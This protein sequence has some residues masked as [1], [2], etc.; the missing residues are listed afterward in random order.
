VT[1]KESAKIGD[2]SYRLLFENSFDAVMMTRPDGSV[3][4]ANPAACRMFGMSE[5]EIVD[6][7]REG[8]VVKDERLELAL[9]DRETTGKVDAELMFRRKDGSTFVGQAISVL[10]KEPDGSI[11]A[12]LI[13]RDITERKRFEIE[14]QKTNEKLY[15]ILSN[16]PY[17]ILLV[18]DEDK[19]EFANQ[20]FC[21]IFD[22]KDP[23]D[24]LT[25]LSAKEMIER[26]RKSYKDPDAAVARISE[27]VMGE[28]PV[29]DED[30]GMISER[31]YLRDFIPIKLMEKRYGRLWI[32]KD[33]T[34][35]M[36][37]EEALKQSE[38]RFRLALRNA[39]VSVA[40]QDRDLRFIWAYNQ[41]SA[42]HDQIIGKLDSDI[43]T[44]EEAVHLTTLKRRVID[45]NIEISEKMW[46]DRPTGKMFLDVF[47]EPW[48]DKEGRVIGVG[49]ATV[50][51]TRMK[52]VE[53]ALKENEE[54]LAE[55]QRI[56][57]LGSWEWNLQTGELR[58]SRQLYSIYGVDPSTFVPTME[59]FADYIHPDDRDLVNRTIQQALSDG[60]PV[61]FD[62]RIISADGSVHTLN[63]V[64]EITEFD[65]NGRP[66]IM[67]GSN[68]DITE[69]KK[70]EAALLETKDF[71]EKL[72][73][74]ANAPIIVWGPDFTIIRF[75][76][77]FE[78][79]TG[80]GS[81][82]VVGRHLE[83][84][85]PQSSRRDS[86]A[87][88]AR[89]SSGEHWDSVEI[90]IKRKDGTT[91]TVLWNS[92]TL[93]QPGTSNISATIAQGQ[94]ITE[95]VMAEEALRASEEKANE[96]IR[97]SPA[98]I[99]ELDYRV[100][101]FTKV[102]DAMCHILGYS[103]EELLSMSPEQIMDEES[104]RRFRERLRALLSGEKVD[105]T[106]EFGVRTKD[107][108]T[109]FA[110]LNVRIIYHAGR[111]EGAFVV[112]H[113]VTE[114][115]LREEELRRSNAELQ[116]FA[117]VASHDLQEPL[118]MVVSHLSL[119]E[120]RYKDKLDP[121]AEEHIRH[122]VEGGERMRQLIDDLLEYSRVET[123][124]EPFALVD[125]NLVVATTL[126]NLNVPIEENQAEI[127]V[128]SLPTIMAD[129]S[130]M[131][132]VIQNLV[133][134]ALKFHSRK[135][136][137]VHISGVEGERE[138]TF[139]VEDNGIGLNM[140]YADKIF[141]MFQRLHTRDS[142][143]GTGVGLAIA[144]K[145]VERHGGRIWVES[146]EGKGATFLF[147]IPKV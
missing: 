5:D 121:K 105:D 88:I 108:R 141:Q 47:Y 93:F 79:L 104:K 102:N 29:K 55:A 129:E 26:I 6:A 131:A 69:R 61:N 145:I 21:D 103:R 12:S 64:G 32:H 139:A 45:E 66:R 146:E 17:G 34:D 98:G 68:L 62:F 72:I 106:V 86:L 110:I 130:Q 41:R 39:P 38:E 1:K 85:F 9:R 101:V 90:P 76:H 123:K 89:T 51:M 81:N 73:G 37:A 25:K 97:Y 48:H 91:K 122:A 115:H 4:T 119:L 132:Q 54:S 117:Y 43:F 120:R 42:A 136:P 60:T 78:R 142:Y 124:G 57:K 147:T 71:L 114:R 56:A 40:V 23:P 140:E 144:K 70:T 16:M 111:P 80:Y 87:H 116:Q 75:N 35:R 15:Q 143:P 125:M 13:I 59:A 10:F 112:A 96:L 50:D 14:L 24:E 58:W 84:L 100:P 94:D 33:I 82:E 31:T 67:I 107:G 52:L 74:Y 83:M 133:G 127:I 30:V 109:V 99:Y 2:V 126:A 65:A 36:K 137:R 8:L 128:D 27:I 22:L 11:R 113:D 63:T 118:R 92:A 46:F 20:E 134:N 44:A 28:G 7:G 95:R 77:A 49:T 53:T 19:I 135:R 138:W 18:S 3:L